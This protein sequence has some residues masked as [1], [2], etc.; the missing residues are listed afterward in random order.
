MTWEKNSIYVNLHFLIYISLLIISCIIEYVTNKR[1]L[2]LEVENFCNI[3]NVF[4]VTFS[5]FNAS[6]QNKTKRLTP[7]VWSIVYDFKK[8]LSVVE[9]DLY[10]T[11]L[12]K[13]IL[14]L[15]CW[16]FSVWLCRCFLNVCFAYTS[17]YEIANA[18]KEMAW[19]VEQGLIKSR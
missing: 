15:C 12:L 4:T 19:G 2:N 9:H 18:V 11:H 5:Q 6:F 3:L 17:R 7:N 1:T 14:L 10:L 8:I 13:F 16:P